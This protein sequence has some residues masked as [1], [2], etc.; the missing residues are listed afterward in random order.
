MQVLHI[1]VTHGEERDGLA[2]VCD[3]RFTRQSRPDWHG[4]LPIL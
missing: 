3:T 2:E 4:L 1:G